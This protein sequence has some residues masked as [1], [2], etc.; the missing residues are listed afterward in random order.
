MNQTKGIK[1]VN[2]S[3]LE[4]VVDGFCYLWLASCLPCCWIYLHICSTNMN[5]VTLSSKSKSIPQNI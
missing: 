4:V 5:V 3:F 1:H 2:L